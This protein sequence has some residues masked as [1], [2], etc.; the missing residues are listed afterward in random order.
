M[1]FIVKREMKSREREHNILESNNMIARLHTGNALANT[2]DNTSTLMS[3]DDG[4]S[5]L[6]IL[7]GEGVGI[8]MADTGVVDLYSDFVG[9]WWCNLNI[10][11]CQVLAGF[12]GNGGLAGDGLS[13]RVSRHDVYVCMLQNA[14]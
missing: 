7:A 5:T 10:L 14:I 3:Q 9:L 4:E 11:D 1:G 13:H 6:G 12:P 2:L 8:G